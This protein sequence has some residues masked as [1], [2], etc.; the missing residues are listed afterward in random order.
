MLQRFCC[1]SFLFKPLCYVLYIFLFQVFRSNTGRT[2]LLLGLHGWYF[3]SISH[4]TFGTYLLLL[5]VHNSLEISMLL[6]YFSCMKDF[7]DF[8]IVFWMW[9]WWCHNIFCAVRCLDLMLKLLYT[10]YCW[11]STFPGSD[12]FLYSCSCRFFHYW[13]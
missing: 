6:W 4:A 7:C 1:I 13:W 5:I 8:H 11:L 12:I 10:W 3:L 9:F 2:F